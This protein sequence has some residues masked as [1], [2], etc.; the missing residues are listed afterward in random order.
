[1]FLTPFSHSLLPTSATEDAASYAVLQMAITEGLLP[2]HFPI[3]LW[4]AQADRYRYYWSWFRGDVL[5][6]LS[7][8]TKDK[9]P[10][11]RYPLKINPIRNFARKH[12][13]LVLGD[14]PD[15]PQ[16]VIKSVV[17][18]KL[19][20]F[21]GSPDEKTREVA[22]FVENSLNEVWHGSNSNSI[23]YENAVIS[24]H[25]GGHVLK[26]N[27]SPWRKD[28]LIPIWV[29][30]LVPD[31]FLPLWSA[32]NP[33]DLLE[34]YVIY[35]IPRAAAERQWPL[36]KFK[37]QLPYSVYCE[38]W[39]KDEYSIT[40]DG[41]PLEI[42]YDG[43][44]MKYDKTENVFGVVP[45]AYIPR[46]R[47]GGYYGASMVPDIDGLAMEFNSRS[48]DIGDAIRKSVHRKWLGRN[49]AQ[50]PTERELNKAEKFVD[51][52]N[53]NPMWEGPPELWAADSPTWSPEMM[54]YNDFL[55]DQLLRE[56]SLGPTAFGH[57]EGSQRSALTLAF[58]MWPSTISARAQRLFWTDGLN[59]IDHII[60]RMMES[61]K[62]KVNG[63]SIP[64]DSATMFDVNKDWL[65]MIPRDRESEVSEII[66]RAQTELISTETALEMFG[67]IP[68]VQQEVERIREWM[69]F[70]SSQETAKKE[71]VPGVKA[72]I[73]SVEAA[74]E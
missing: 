31:F 41:V 29:R 46:Y 39:T 36:I 64:L 1:M 8:E 69:E 45:F 52:G 18:P 56:G 63:K 68:D 27:Y 34:C 13:A 60:L 37:T 53:T 17:K 62:I 66:L 9:R 72:P 19:A 74:G 42:R 73:A 51:I 32:D 54:K 58:R 23:F 16:H 49:L 47:E 7:A 67:N 33:W 4:Q 35:R 38:H 70:R 40:V 55:W 20:Y 26:V 15:T 5:Q 11:Y 30:N 25:L 28:L 21:G 71:P 14:I 57:D 6:E 50:N 10:I 61:Q 65:S 3:A 48:A 22:S 2:P 24:Q 44:K 59:A 12:A 43:G